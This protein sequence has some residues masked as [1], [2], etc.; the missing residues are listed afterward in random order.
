MLGVHKGSNGKQPNGG[1]RRG[2]PKKAPFRLTL[3]GKQG[4][5]QT[6]QVNISGK[7]TGRCK[8]GEMGTHRER[9]GTAKGHRARP[10]MRVQER[11][12]ERPTVRPESG[13]PSSRTCTE[14]IC[15]FIK[16]P[17]VATQRRDRKRKG[18]RRCPAG[19]LC[20]WSGSGGGEKEGQP[21]QAG[22]AHPLDPEQC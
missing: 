10:E 3:K 6:E 5:Q 19:R 7:G 12:E 17:W 21:Q 16:S 11:Q 4:P 15:I 1:N 8:D 2:F 14:W 18:G 9:L 13:A 22:V 20:Q